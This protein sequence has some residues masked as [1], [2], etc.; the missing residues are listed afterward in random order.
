MYNL[1]KATADIYFILA[2]CTSSSLRSALRSHQRGWGLLGSIGDLHI[3]RDPTGGNRTGFT[4]MR[5]LGKQRGEEQQKHQLEDGE[6]MLKEDEWD[7]KLLYFTLERSLNRL[8]TFGLLGVSSTGPLRS[9]RNA[10]GNRNYVILSILFVFFCHLL[11]ACSLRCEC[12]QP[13]LFSCL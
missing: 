8:G 13:M 2:T 3:L 1:R 10:G 5:S 12:S 7:N 6:N 9:Y 4:K 11:C